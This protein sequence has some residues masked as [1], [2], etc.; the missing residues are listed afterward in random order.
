LFILHFDVYIRDFG[1]N[2]GYKNLDRKTF[3]PHLVPP[4]LMVWCSDL[5]HVIRVLYVFVEEGGCDDAKVRALILAQ[6]E[7]GVAPKFHNPFP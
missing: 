5:L 1:P 6:R 4:S 2:F 3:Q 7:A